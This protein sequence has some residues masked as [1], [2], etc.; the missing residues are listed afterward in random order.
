[1]AWVRGEKTM[2]F[3]P[4][5]EHVSVRLVDSVQP[6]SNRLTVCNQ[7]TY[8]S[9]AAAE[10]ADARVY[11]GIHTRSAVEDGTRQGENI[12][13]YVHKHALRPLY[14]KGDDD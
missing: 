8:F 14:E 1:M 5:G 13:R 12:G 10:N 4:N 2:P 11:A 7:W 3:G 9:E 6:L